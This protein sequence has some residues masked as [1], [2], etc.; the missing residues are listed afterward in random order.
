M[1]LTGA[2]LLLFAA[3]L[4]AA[5]AQTARPEAPKAPAVA[6][7]GS[8]VS[9]TIEGRTLAWPVEIAD[10]GAERS[11]GLMFR[12]ELP[13]MTGML[14]D[15]RATRPVAMWMRNTYV[16]LDMIFICED[17]TVANIGADTVPLSEATVS[18]DGP[19]RYVLEI[20]AGEAA[21]VGLRTGSKLNHPLFADA[22]QRDCTA[23]A[24]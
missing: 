17:G 18:S 9:A 19:V 10:D 4:G 2:A 1:R 20:N 24:G 8:T 12:R 13:A 11:R 23:K 3:T 14:F 22:P 21:K 5:Q 16:P 6:A 7:D 15:F